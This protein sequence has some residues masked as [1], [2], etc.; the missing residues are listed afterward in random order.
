MTQE[1]ISEFEQANRTSEKS[2]RKA[3]S[4]AKHIMQL[5]RL[6]KDICDG[7][8][9]RL[10]D[11]GCGYGE[12]L[13]MC[14]LFGIEAFGVDRSSA[15]REHSNLNTI[16]SEIE[17]L[18]AAQL[19]RFHVI[20]LFEVL[21]HLDDPRSI[22]EMLKEYLVTGGILVLETPDCSGVED[23][24]TLDDYRKIHPLDHINGFTPDTMRELAKRIGFEPIRKPVSH[25]TSDPMRVA[26]TEIK[27][28]VGSAMGAST[29]QYFRKR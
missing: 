11:F 9:I 25:V 16:F 28:L 5:E 29:Q 14:A 2:F 21:E 23:I 15:K 27:R 19:P 18:D 20:T 7:E 13:M 17:D 22:L 12:F 26:K 3:V 8:P 4:N 1:A 24:L 10:L 6:T